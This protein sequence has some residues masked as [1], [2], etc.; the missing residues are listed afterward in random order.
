MVIDPLDHYWKIL[1]GEAE[2]G[3]KAAKRTMVDVDLESNTEEL[4]RVHDGAASNTSDEEAISLLNLKTELAKRMLFDCTLCE[5]A[6]HVNR[7]GGEKGHCGVLGAR[8]SSEFLHF[9]EEP[10]LIPSHTI[11]FSGCTFDCVFCQNSDISTRPESGVFIP[12]QALAE[13]IEMKAPSMGRPAK[14]VTMPTP[15]RNV[16]WVGGDP[17]SNIAYILQVL[18][19]CEANL[20]QVW[21]SNMYLSDASLRL[22]D[23]IIDV[24]LTDF[25][26]GNDCCAKR[27]SNVD[28]YWD[29][30]RRNHLAARTQGEMIIRHL[31][32]PSHLECCTRPILTWIADSLS[33]VK[34]N[35]M[36]QYRPCHNAADFEEIARPLRSLE[37]SLA[38]E[39]AEDLKLDLCV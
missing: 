14:P 11:F 9:G 16:N 35:V 8:I 39:I 12:P 4:W 31:V 2:A 34:V 29:I 20:P 27:L 36:G 7:E 1:N 28:G 30:I 6:C 18:A 21:N 13:M 5:R 38:L 19:H 26:Y 32:L 3:Y 33:A 24:Y 22:L 37:Y 25:K 10:E 23:G 15:S 17:T